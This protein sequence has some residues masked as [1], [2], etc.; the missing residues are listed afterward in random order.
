MGWLDRPA[1]PLPSTGQHT[2]AVLWRA[3]LERRNLLLPT[4]RRPH[5]GCYEWLEPR[6]DDKPRPHPANSHHLLT[7][8]SP[9]PDL[10]CQLAPQEV[11]TAIHST[12]PPA[13]AEPM[14]PAEEVIAQ[15]VGPW[16][17]PPRRPRPPVVLEQ[18]RPQEETLRGIPMEIGIQRT[19]PLRKRPNLQTVDTEAAHLD[20][21]GS[22]GAQASP[23]R[24]ILSTGHARYLWPAPQGPIL[25]VGHWG[26]RGEPHSPPS[27]SELG[28]FPR[29]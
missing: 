3:V 11:T 19:P 24:C 17:R 28:L 12:S 15:D 6:L 2:T 9:S 4:H 29:A 26:H 21:T 23:Y 14:N 1:L 8:G 7:V 16:A 18:P 20:S 10:Q 25:P 27:H 13:G 5:S 22:T